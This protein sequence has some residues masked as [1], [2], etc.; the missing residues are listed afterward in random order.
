MLKIVIHN[1]IK[2]YKDTKKKRKKNVPKYREIFPT[3]IVKTTDFQLVFNY[4]LY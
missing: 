4:L 2:I 3:L 1:K